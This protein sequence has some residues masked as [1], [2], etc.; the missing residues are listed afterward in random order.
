MQ[1][2][3]VTETLPG[4]QFAELIQLKQLVQHIK[5]ELDEIGSDRP[6]FAK[7]NFDESSDE[8]SDGDTTDSSENHTRLGREKAKTLN[9]CLLSDPLQQDNNGVVVLSVH[10]HDTTQIDSAHRETRVPQQWGVCVDQAEADWEVCFPLTTPSSN[11][12]KSW[13]RTGGIRKK[14]AT[15]HQMLSHL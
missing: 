10:E 7:P 13:W 8:E 3:H 15:I 12:E 5:E 14:T 1:L 9:L 11:L 4:Q 2:L 6:D